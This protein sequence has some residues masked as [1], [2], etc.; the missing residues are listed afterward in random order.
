MKDGIDILRDEIY[1]L[2]EKNKKL[3][4]ENKQLRE[5]LKEI[6]ELSNHGIPFYA[7]GDNEAGCKLNY[8]LNNINMIIINKL[9]VLDKLLNQ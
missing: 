2:E 3:E 8:V 4:A 1:K 7:Y 5:L 9:P 6:Q